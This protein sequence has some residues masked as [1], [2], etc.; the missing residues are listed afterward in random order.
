MNSN[1]HKQQTHHAN[2]LLQEIGK[3]A[4][5]YLT[6]TPKGKRLLQLPHPSTMAQTIVAIRECADSLVIVPNEF[7]KAS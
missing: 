1:Q 5:V 3:A 6:R 7:S 4:P 2:A